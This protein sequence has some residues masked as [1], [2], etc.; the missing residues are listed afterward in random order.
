MLILLLFFVTPIFA[1]TLE[2]GCW[3]SGAPL[4]TPRQEMQ[5]ALLNGKIF[6]IGGLIQGGDGTDLVEVYDS[7]NNTWSTSTPLPQK[8]HHISTAE[9]NGKIYVLG[10]YLNNTFQPTDA[11]YEFDPATS[12]W[13]S[14]ASMP[15]HRGAATAAVVNGLIYVIGG[16]AN[17]GGVTDTNEVFDPVTNTW[18]SLAPMPT[19]REHLA[20]AAIGSI[21]YIVGGRNGANKHKFEAY[22]TTTNSWTTLPDLPTARSGLTACPYGSRIFVFGGEIP[23]VY[24]KNEVYDPSTNLWDEAAPMPTARHGVGSTFWNN[25]IYIIGGGP[26]EGYGVSNVNER[27]TLD[28][29]PFSDDFADA[30]ISD[31]LI[32]KGTWT[33]SNGFLTGTNKRKGE[34]RSIN[35]GCACCKAIASM[36]IVTP[37]A[38]ASLLTH[39]LDKN[40]Y[41]EV[42]MKE[43]NDKWVVKHWVNGSIA[44]KSSAIST[45]NIGQMYD[46]QIEYLNGELQL[47][48]DGTL[49]VHFATAQPEQGTSGFR[50]KSTTQNSAT[51]TIDSITVN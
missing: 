17:P 37:D 7:Q 19:A 1:Q 42:L 18:Q 20:S 31:W 33:A 25:A 45:I 43:K 16:V 40:N 4:P 5:Q 6:V 2:D 47:T 46:V 22:D 13:T 24:K 27:F 23:G 9:V 44:A 10:G 29:S 14:K 35:A 15:N 8:M 12:N 3:L 39:Y 48:V 49:L 41:V 21:I 34:I 30:D 26:V 51:V 50:I 36:E 38:R 32:I 28:P 11:V